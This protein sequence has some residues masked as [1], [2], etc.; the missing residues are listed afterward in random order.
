MSDLTLEDAQAV[1]QA[2]PFSVL[3]GAQISEFR[4]GH[5]VL[6]IPVTDQL[7]QQHGYVHGGVVAY[8]VDNAV[9]FA[10]GSVLGPAVLTSGIAV[11]YVAPCSGDLEARASV[12]ASTSRTATCRCEVVVD[13]TVCAV[14]Q[15]TVRAIGRP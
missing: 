9:T 15:G 14:G 3:L 2:Q 13:G 7:R 10:A 4:P 1:L 12:V 11:D 6:T 8:A 5:A